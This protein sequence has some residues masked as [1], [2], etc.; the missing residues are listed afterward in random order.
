M[1]RNN[2]NTQVGTM[3]RRLAVCCLLL[4]SFAGQMMA[5]TDNPYVLKIKTQIAGTDHYLSHVY[6]ESEG[7]WELQDA[8]TFNPETCIWY[9]GP[10]FNV[11]G[12]HHNYYFYD[13]EAD[14]YHFLSAPLAGSQDLGF[15]ADLPT[16]SHLKNPDDI[17]YFYDWDQDQYGGGVARG[18]DDNGWWTVHWVAYSNFYQKWL[19]TEDYYSIT[20]SCAMYRGVTVFQNDRNLTLT[21]SEIGDLTDFA[22]D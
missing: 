19:T 20:D 7:R 18:H 14:K 6:N 10:V 8:T 22:M 2:I 9:S 3:A 12:N 5:Q 11:S 15:S 1:K 16:S 21:Q 13:E 17:Y 4:W